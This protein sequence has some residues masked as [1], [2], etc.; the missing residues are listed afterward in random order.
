MSKLTLRTRNIL[1]GLVAV[2]CIGLIVAASFLLNQGSGVTTTP[3]ANGNTAATGSLPA[4]NDVPTESPAPEANSSD[5]VPSQTTVQ[6]PSSTEVNGIFVPDSIMLEAEQIVSR[7]VQDGSITLLGDT[8]E[9]RAQHF[10]QLTAAV[11]VTMYANGEVHDQPQSFTMLDRDFNVSDDTWEEITSEISFADE[12]S[13]GYSP[14]REALFTIFDHTIDGNDG[15]SWVT[16]ASGSGRMSGTL[17]PGEYLYISIVA[18]SMFFSYTTMD[19]DFDRGR[20]TFVSSPIAQL[21]RA[22]H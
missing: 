15:T 7:Q 1:I 3:A 14:I 21:V 5:A 11:A 18:S 9:T 13:L 2:V 10:S 12:D 4:T 6:I 19:L 22:L 16:R 20:L 17:N 8:A